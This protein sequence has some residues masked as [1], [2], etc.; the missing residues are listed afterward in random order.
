MTF[1]NPNQSSDDYQTRRLTRRLRHFLPK[2][3]MLCADLRHPRPSLIHYFAFGSNMNVER[4]LTDRLAPRGVALEAILPAR[5]EGYRL[6]FDKRADQFG[7]AGV[8]NIVRSPG[9]V[10]HGTLN[11]MSDAGL[12]VLDHYEGVA[13]N[14]YQRIRIGVI[15][16]DGT[17]IDAIAYQAQPPFSQ[18]A[19]PAQRYLAHLLA[20]QAH[21]PVDYFNQLRC[22]PTHD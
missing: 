9:D 13:S 14:M 12:D 5:L 7:G 8:A 6:T 22:W 10:V 18:D 19:K 4:L 20:G 11:A 2:S 21:L 16:P 1:F 15:T 3:G 17:A